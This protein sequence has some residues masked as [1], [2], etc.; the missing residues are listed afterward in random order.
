MLRAAH[1]LT[2]PSRTPSPPCHHHHGASYLARKAR[3]E[4][5]QWAS[6]APPEAEA[7]WQAAVADLDAFKR[8]AAVYSLYGRKFKTVLVRRRGGRA[9]AQ[10]PRRA[11]SRPL[12]PP[13]AAR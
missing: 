4:P 13:A 11:P 1:P 2:T 10:P 9:R 6:A 12:G 5:R 3:E 8:Q 7:R